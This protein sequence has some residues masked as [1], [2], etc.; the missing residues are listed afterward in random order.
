METNAQ[1]H[2]PRAIIYSPIFLRHL[3]LQ[4]I[5]HFIGWKDLYEKLI[6]GPKF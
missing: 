4:Y 5:N 6:G 2:P 1:I 3:Q